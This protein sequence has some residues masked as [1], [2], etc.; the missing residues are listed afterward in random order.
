MVKADY[1]TDIVGNCRCW[2]GADNT[3]LLIFFDTYLG[4][5]GDVKR[6]CKFNSSGYLCKCNTCFHAQECERAFPIQSLRN[7]G[8]SDS[9][10]CQAAFGDP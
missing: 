5:L 4:E 7:S 9:S 10:I 8:C 2:G 1:V 3:G 6:G